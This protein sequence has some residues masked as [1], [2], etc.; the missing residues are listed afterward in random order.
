MADVL[1]V[2]PPK[3]YLRD[4]NAQF[5]LGLLY[6]E[7]SARKEGFETKVLNASSLSLE[8]TVVRILDLDPS[9]IGYT[10]T[11]LD[12][13]YIFKIQDELEKKKIYP[14]VL[15]GPC[16]FAFLESD[17]RLRFKSPFTICIGEGE[18]VI[19]RIIQDLKKGSPKKS[20]T[21]FNE[22]IKNLPRPDRTLIQDDLSGNV[23]LSTRSDKATI[24]LSSRG[25]VFKCCFCTAPHL[26]KGKVRFRDLSDFSRELDEIKDLGVNY[27]RFSDDNFSLNRNF[28]SEVCKLLREKGF[29]FRVSCRTKPNDLDFFKLLKDSGCLEIGFGVETCDERVL[30]VIGKGQTVSD[31]EKALTNAKKAGLFV[32]VLLMSNLPGE[33][34]Q[35]SY[36][37][38][39]VLNSLP[40]DSISVTVLK[41]FPGSEIWRNPQKFGCEIIDKDF[42]SYNIYA[43]DSLGERP[44]KPAIRPFNLDLWEVRKNIEVLFDWAKKTGKLNKG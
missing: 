2:H 7:A 29:Y 27:L 40:W 9:V 44:H 33:D 41:P 23:F 13:P 34:S 3:P 20:Y 15:G 11:V 21:G 4:P 28:V 30:K 10:G 6:V 32:R 39:S 42:F 8:E 5:P 17:L 19:G 36:R 25:C 18:P 38:I 26:S 22:D 43:Y 1:F 31:I 37:T 24:I 35:S 14:F 16:V 12:L